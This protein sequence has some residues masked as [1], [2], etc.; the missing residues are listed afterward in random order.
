MPIKEPKKKF[1][2]FTLNSVGKI[3]DIKKGIPP[4]KR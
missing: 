4:I 1:L 2:T 3:L